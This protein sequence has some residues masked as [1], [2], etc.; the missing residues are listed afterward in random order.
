MLDVRRLRLLRELH[1]RGT[2]AAVADAMNYTPS[3]ISQQLAALEREAGVPL[4]ERQGRGVRLTDAGRTLV[5]HA[6]AVLERL[7]QAEADLAA[8]AGG[9]SGTVRV[10][11][12]QTGAGRIV[13]PAII[14][15]STR[16]PRLRLELVEMEAEQSLPQLRLGDVDIAVAEEY[17]HAP[18]RRHPAV[19]RHD[20]GRDR[21]RLILPAD[22]AA[23][24]SGRAVPLR[25][26]A[27][28]AW[29]GPSEGTRYS[30]MMDRECRAIGGF[31]PDVQH[32]TDD[33]ALILTLVAS[34]LGVS[35]VPALGRP[36]E[37]PGVAVRDPTARP[38]D[39]SIFAGVRRGSASHPAV[40]AVLEELRERA[41][42]AG[43]V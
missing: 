38:L 16:F 5:D 20:L 6:E 11:S 43:L 28:E 17:E 13:A 18:R 7:E 12:F 24:A 19:E 25:R 36:E 40:A 21:L 30:E 23:A 27:G 2:I 29:V 3:A 32:R 14:R 15:L 41:R 35:L 39:R 26:L 10:A 31:E 9:V 33:I 22:H 1:T 4:L 8:A 34:G 42:A 37:R